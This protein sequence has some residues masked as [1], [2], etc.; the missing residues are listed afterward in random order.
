MIKWLKKVFCFGFEDDNEV[1]KAERVLLAMQGSIITLEDRVDEL[2][3]WLEIALKS[4]PCSEH[5]Y[6]ARDYCISTAPIDTNWLYV[7]PPLVVKE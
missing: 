2:E 1:A 4:L 5:K 3:E 6:T 7:S